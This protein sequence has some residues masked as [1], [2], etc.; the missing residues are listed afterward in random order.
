MNPMAGTFEWNAIVQAAQEDERH[1]KD[2]TTS[3]HIWKALA[4]SRWRRE[5]RERYVQWQEQ[6][7]AAKWKRDKPTDAKRDPWGWTKTFDH[8][9]ILERRFVQWYS[10]EHLIR[11]FRN[12]FGAAN[13]PPEEEKEFAREF[14]WRGGKYT[15]SMQ[16]S[17]KTKDQTYQIHKHRR[18][19]KTRD[20]ARRK[21][22]TTH[23]DNLC[24][25]ERPQEGRGG[26]MRGPKMPR[27][28]V[29]VLGRNDMELKY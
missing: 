12:E 3:V 11:R 13:L 10:K 2:Y 17:R 22:N 15:P 4:H 25:V 20:Q 8:P 21:G 5:Q 27:F 24:D 28:S 26:S 16:S 19:G 23:K 1:G 7:A 9:D 14:G 29:W 18:Q 6:K